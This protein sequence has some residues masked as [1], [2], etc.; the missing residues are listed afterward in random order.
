MK[1]L[2]T[3][4]KAGIPL[5]LLCSLAVVA[6]ATAVAAPKLGG[7]AQP[8]GTVALAQAE[9]APVARF[10]IRYKTPVKM[11]G[12]RGATQATER[13][14]AAAQVTRSAS[15]SGASNLRYL[16]S[17]AADLHVVVLEQAVS[18]AEAQA[19]MQRLRADAAVEDVV[20]DHR[21]QA[22]ALPNDP[23][24]VPDSLY[25]QWH[26]QDSTVVPGGIN[27]R[28]VWGAGS[29]GSGVVVA[30]VDGG[31]RPHADLEANV[32]PGY[33]FISADSPSKFG[34]N[35][36]WTANDGDA[37]D[38]D[39][40]DPGDWITPDDVTNG[41][42]DK[43]EESSWHG[44]H[45]AGLAG[46]VGNNGVGGLGVAYG[47][48]LLPV[49][50]LGRCGGYSSD[51]LAGARWAAGLEVPR[52]P[53]NPTPAKVLNLSLGVGGVACDSTTQSIVDEIRA[54]N[55]VSI[56]ASAG[57]DG[58]TVLTM[59]ANCKGVVAVTAH[60]R[61]GDSAD[62]ANVG[63]GTAISA[64]GGGSNTLLATL[65][66]SPRLIASTGNAGTTTPAGD[67]YLLYNGTSMAAPQVA[68]VLAL[69][70]FLRPDLPMTTLEEIVIGSA[71]PFPAGGYCATNPDQLPAGFCGSGLLDA[72]KAVAA[73]IAFVA[74][75]APAS[76]GGGGGG[77]CTVATNGQADAGLVLLA[78]AALLM[79]ARR[80]RQPR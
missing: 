40:R 72:E 1:F 5:A 37:R 3:A 74:P 29:T 16:K 27:V 60:T 57:N 78:L 32:L 62:Y 7:K 35:I 47:A 71:R 67:N 38:P 51:I 49:R 45:V 68:G 8:S 20:I 69:L 2:R 18:P 6:T 4:A 75:V 14:E 80:R 58:S 44:T 56:V 79:L 23:Y 19:L 17:V 59:P 66:G 30:V 46:A 12:Q 11:A 26:L 21:M 39:A 43:A 63:A 24:L 9:Q 25:N 65:P 70:A 13:L 36:H 73:V 50:V 48:Q 55:K 15:V 22:H 42:C 41:Y 61:E 34:R 28:S 54:R 10:M 53:A 76:D 77:G 64:P 52:V 31:Y 33:D